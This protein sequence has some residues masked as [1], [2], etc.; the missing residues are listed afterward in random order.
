MSALV[1]EINVDELMTRIREEVARRKQ[2]LGAASNP[3]SAAPVPEQ[4]PAAP[5]LAE[6]LRHEGADGVAHAYRTLLRREPESGAVEGRLSVLAE[7]GVAAQVEMLR[8]MCASE[9]GQNAGAEVL[10]LTKPYRLG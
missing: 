2:Q 1:P 4:R 9:E 10:G 3:V 6:L 5:G 8:E 7:G